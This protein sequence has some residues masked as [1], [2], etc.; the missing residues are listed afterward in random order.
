MV[1]EALPTC[2]GRTKN[3]NT[4]HRRSCLTPKS[5]LVDLTVVIRKE[6]E[7]AVLVRDPESDRPA[8]W[9]PKSQIEIEWA[10]RHHSRA[11]ITGERWFFEEK[12]LI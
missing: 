10:D 8:V 1:G 6:T 7:L 2:R 11:T 9:L 5:E 4:N 3:G 12:E